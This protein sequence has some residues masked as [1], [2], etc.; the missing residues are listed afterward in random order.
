M[1]TKLY[2]L[3]KSRNNA[4]L[5]IMARPRGNEWLE[6][7]IVHFKKQDI[8]VIV[9]LLESS[10]IAE[11]GLKDEE[12]LC[13]KHGIV[14]INFPIPDRDIPQSKEKV[15]VLISGLIAKLD[16][17]VSIAIHCRMGIGRSS[18]IAAAVL[19]KEGGKPDDIIQHVSKI[20]GVNV[21]DTNQQLEWFKKRR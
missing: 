6:D 5:A 21:P 1:H 13:I 3:Y 16:E 18:I 9:S 7:E 4:R 11:L 19:L 15:E 14:Y 20:R 17:G 10:E 2:W 12:A 8:G